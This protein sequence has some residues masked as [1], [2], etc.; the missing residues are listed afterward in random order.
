MEEEGRCAKKSF[1]EERAPTG[2]H[3]DEALRTSMHDNNDTRRWTTTEE[4]EDDNDDEDEEGE[5]VV[6]AVGEVR[7]VLRVPVVEGVVVVTSSN[8]TRDERRGDE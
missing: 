7:L 5:T 1:E 8:A 4:R 6:P 2:G 3:N